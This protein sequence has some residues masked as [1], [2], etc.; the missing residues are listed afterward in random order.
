[1]A[2]QYLHSISQRLNDLDKLSLKNCAKDTGSCI[3]ITKDAVF[4][5]NL[6]LDRCRPNQLIMTNEHKQL[7]SMDLKEFIKSEIEKV[8]PTIQITQTPT[9]ITQPVQQIIQ[10]KFEGVMNNLKIINDEG[11]CLTLGRGS[12]VINF[13]IDND[14]SLF[15]SNGKNEEIDIFIPKLN[16]LSNIDTTTPMDGSITI[17]G[18]LGIVRNLC[19]GGGI[20][21]KTDDGV[22]TELDY[23]EEGS[24]PI[25]FAGPWENDVDS[26]V[27]YQR[28]GSVVTLF[29]PYTAQKAV[30]S[31]SIH[32]TVESYLPERLRPVFDI[33]FDIDTI[34]S[35]E[36]EKGKM[37]F[38]GDDGRI[39]IQTDKINFEP[40]GLCGFRTKCVNFM[41]KKNQS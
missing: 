41:V 26:I 16:F 12:D 21:L 37:I 31:N 32:N 29:I 2:N 5:N 19:V 22:P 14:G 33:E 3:S 17:Y 39:V 7:V 18:G 1:M 27:N 9:Q 13:N 25:V 15:L 30:V 38:Y 36:N 34:N 11:N 20:L 8:I 10:P 4:W 24:I 6:V 23:F 28:I 35:S 40:T